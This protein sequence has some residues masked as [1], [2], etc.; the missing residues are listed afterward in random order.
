MIKAT[1]AAANHLCFPS[2]SKGIIPS[3]IS[4]VKKKVET[5]HSVHS[6]LSKKKKMKNSL[7]KRH[8]FEPLAATNFLNEHHGDIDDPERRRDQRHQSEIADVMKYQML[9]KQRQW[10]IKE[11]NRIR[12]VV[13]ANLPPHRPLWVPHY[14]WHWL[15]LAPHYH[16]YRHRHRV[17]WR[18]SAQMVDYAKQEMDDYI[19]YDQFDGF[20]NEMVNPLGNGF[21]LWEDSEFLAERMREFQNGL[22]FVAVAVVF[23]VTLSC[24]LWRSKWGSLVR[25]LNERRMERNRKLYEAKFAN[26]SSEDSSSLNISDVSPV[27]EEDRVV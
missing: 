25:R 15:H 26:M 17:P 23:C 6:V 22:L 24:F 8:G 18:S 12:H 2:N 10:I 11:A 5:K 1:K 16:L 20:E 7:R 4:A 3:K 27:N 9:Q 14:F 19:D 21:D 13:K